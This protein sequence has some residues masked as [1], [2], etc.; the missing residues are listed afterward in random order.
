MTPTRT[1]WSTAAFVLYA[2]G[3]TVLV[4]IVALLA[5]I[6]SHHRVGVFVGLAF[7]VW[8]VATMLAAVVQATTRPVAGGL[9]ALTSAASLVVFLGALLDWF[10]WLSSKEFLNGFQLGNLLLELV[11]A[12][13]FF[14]AL[15]IFRFP[16]L[17]LF[18]T[19]AAWIFVADLVS[20]GG[21]WTAW[22]ALFLGIVLLGIG[23]GANPV[24]GFWIHVV[25]GLS[26]GGAL[27]Y[28]FHH[29][30]ARWLL[31]GAAALI[32]VGI[33]GVL[34]RS[35]YAVLGVFG[36]FLSFSHF[37]EQGLNVPFVT[38]GIGESSRPAWQR[39]LLY[40]VF[41]LALMVI[42]L[43]MLVRRSQEKEA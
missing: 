15:W 17:V 37:V 2:G 19:L 14:T 10:G 1:P 24:Y 43:G 7:I 30:D 39:A 6:S 22:V 12:I 38:L 28:W 5:T 41:G 29:G 11:A 33:A 23:T 42:G 18:G 36:L 8:F 31:L 25:A 27:L 26:A 9:L 21:N 34:E 4:S 40:A 20:N 16:L 35:S 13:V 3:L 32:F